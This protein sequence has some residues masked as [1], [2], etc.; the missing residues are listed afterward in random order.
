M[1]YA[2]VRSPW[3]SRLLVQLFLW[4]TFTVIRGPRCYKVFM[5]DRAQARPNPLL[6]G[7]G[8]LEIFGTV[9]PNEAPAAHEKVAKPNDL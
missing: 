3:S 8:G 1:Y 7:D 5:Q 2:Q 6:T 9:K 4:G